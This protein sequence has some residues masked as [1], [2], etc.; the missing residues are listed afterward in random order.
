M[1]ISIPILPMWIILVIT[2]FVSFT[3]QMTNSDC[4]PETQY[5]FLES[6]CSKCQPGTYMSSAC[7]KSSDT[8]CIPCGPNEYKVVWNK[9]HQCTRHDVCDPGKALVVAHNGNSTYPRKCVCVADYH[10][11]TQSE[12]CMKNKECALGF[13]VQY[14]V[15]TNKDTICV[16]CPLGYFSNY[17]SSKEECKPWTNCTKLGL[18]E[19]VPGTRQSNTVC[20]YRSIPISSNTRV[21]IIVAVVLSA[22]FVLVMGII[23]FVCWRKKL[24]KLTA[25][26]QKWINDVF[27]RSCGVKE[28]S[29]SNSKNSEDH[30]RSDMN[31]LLHKNDPFC[32]VNYAMHEQEGCTPLIGR[33][34]GM[35]AEKSIQGQ[36]IPI[37]DEYTGKIFA[38]QPLVAENDSNST[39]EMLSD[40]DYSSYI[41]GSTHTCLNNCA[42]GGCNI[43]PLH[44]YE[45]FQ[46]RETK[47]NHCPKIFTNDSTWCLSSMEFSEVSHSS[48]STDDGEET[49][50]HSTDS[51]HSSSNSYQDRPTSDT[52]PQPGNNST[53]I[54]N[55]QVMNFNG[56]V[57][58]L[59]VSPN[60]QEVPTNNESNDENMGSPVQEESQ[61]RCDSFVA[62]TQN[63]T[64]KYVDI[65]A[66]SA[67]NTEW[68][69]P[70]TDLADNTE[71][72]GTVDQRLNNQQN[73]VFTPVQEEGKPE[74]FIFEE[75]K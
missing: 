21:V 54:S 58:V 64:E 24:K 44:A 60:T 28:N 53:Y 67:T 55:G 70:A 39:G 1:N 56:D 61:S 18:V 23:C 34:G 10:W 16:A 30:K 69:K 15:Q 47:K 22:V 43:N 42:Q 31:G 65:L 45:Q 63:P 27:Y 20:D 50:Y 8:K 11:N 4:D 7:T 29:S 48:P 5:T 68:W 36:S 33:S 73:M 59:V 17:S 14:P 19:I 62:N 52:P 41:S 57:I 9:D 37:E 46:G 13:G 38:P 49:F 32:T 35:I 75:W 71:R 74:Y 40:T 2:H 3:E 66:G 6:C 51:Q 26:V 72:S 12:F 25:D